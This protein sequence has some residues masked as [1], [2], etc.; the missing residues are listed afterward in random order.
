MTTFALAN[1]RMAENTESVGN[2][3]VMLLVGGKAESV[4]D[5][6]SQSGPTTNGSGRM[7]DYDTRSLCAVIGCNKLYDDVHHIY[8]GS[9]NRVPCVFQKERRSGT[10]GGV[11]HD[12]GCYCN[13]MFLCRG[14]HMAA[15]Q[16]GDMW[17]AEMTGN[18][19]VK[20]KCE[21][22]GKE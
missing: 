5:M 16:R 6:D 22:T 19:W 8:S 13:E 3:R 1:V 11:T 10:P 12:P 14:H 15:H 4:K 17:L 21:L 2:V 9:G 20:L 7:Q 18:N